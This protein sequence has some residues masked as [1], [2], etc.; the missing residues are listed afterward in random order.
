[1]TR[2]SL[3]IAWNINVAT[4]EIGRGI[5]LKFIRYVHISW[6]QVFDKAGQYRVCPENR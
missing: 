4:D 3:T 2:T 5:K 6:E 1:M